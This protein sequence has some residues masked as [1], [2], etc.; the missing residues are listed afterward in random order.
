MSARGFLTRLLAQNENSGS[1]ALDS[2]TKKQEK[3]R[4]MELLEDV[5]TSWR[6]KCCS[7]VHDGS[8]EAINCCS[9]EPV[10]ATDGPGPDAQSWR[11]VG[12]GMTSPSQVLARGCCDDHDFAELIYSCPECD[13]TH[14]SKQE[15]VDCCAF[16]DVDWRHPLGRVPQCMVCMRCVEASTVLPR[17]DPVQWWIEAAKCCLPVKHPSIT[18][19]QC[20]SLGVLLAN[21]SS[22]VD[23]MARIESA[24]TL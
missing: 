21:G 17:T 24:N 4:Q 2:P 7:R 22:W 16:P 19:H 6:C 13:D 5:A 12:C 1:V 20:E 3:Q 15:A 23:A 14:D 11:C 18:S 10:K 8:H 9:H